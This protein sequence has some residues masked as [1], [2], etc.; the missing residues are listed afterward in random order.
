MNIVITAPESTT[1]ASIL[2]DL[3]AGTAQLH[4]ER[5]NGTYRRVHY[6]ADGSTAR[7]HAEWIVAEREEGK[8]MKAIATELHTSVSAIR[9]VINDLLLTEELEHMEAEELAEM[10]RGAEEFEVPASAFADQPET[11]EA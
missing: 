1:P 6:L 3:A 7:E 5:E 8:S 10:L 2:A 11:E 4:K 9:R